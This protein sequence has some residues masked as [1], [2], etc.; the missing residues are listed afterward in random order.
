MPRHGA[1]VVAVLCLIFVLLGLPDLVQA[2]GAP[3]TP[4][5]AAGTT[6]TSGAAPLSNTTITVHKAMCLTIGQEN[7]CNG[8]AADVSLPGYSIKFNVW[9]GDSSVGHGGPIFSLTATLTLGAGSKGDVTSTQTVDTKNNAYTVC[10]VE[11]ANP[12]PSTPPKPIFTLMVTPRPST[13]VTPLSTSGQ[14][15]LDPANS[16]CIVQ[17]AGF[18]NGN[19]EFFFLDTKGPEGSGAIRINKTA[20]D[21][22]NAATQ[23]GAV[24]SI[25]T[26]GA[27]G[28]EVATATVGGAPLNLAGV[29]CA[30]GLP[31]GPKYTVVETKPPAGYA[32][33]PA[34]VTSGVTSAATCA[35][36]PNIASFSDSPGGAIRINKTARD[37]AAPASQNG[38]VFSI[39]T[40]DGTEVAEAT[41]GGDPLKQDG[42]ACAEGLPLGPTY[43]VM[44]TQPPAGYLP[45]SQ[46][47]TSGVTSAAT[48]ANGPNTTSFSDALGG[49]ILI[50]KFAGDGA[51]AATQ[52]G[53]IFSI[54]TDGNEVAEATVGGD[55]L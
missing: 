47:S 6:S 16:K 14:Q 46:T 40:S 50:N 1:G 48:C 22:A 24:F 29:A 26:G 49:A 13:T 15:H 10:E 23:N 7:T 35:N 18:S 52:N 2:Q 12:P 21:N 42:V 43:T 41:V 33:N 37:G 17:P 3:A 9:Q 55:P 5:P 38:A 32:V 4:T 44:E 53:A 34:T 28:T 30:E 36:G 25:R 45:N 11:I 54:L 51:G 31:L 19:P 20:R 27:T 39:R 8:S